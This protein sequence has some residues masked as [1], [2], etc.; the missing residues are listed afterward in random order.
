MV[1]EGA[2]NQ[3]GG[4]LLKAKDALTCLHNSVFPKRPP[5]ASLG[6]LAELLGLEASTIGDFR[7]EQMVCGSQSTLLMLPRHGFECDFDKT[8]SVVPRGPD[9]KALSLSSF[10]ARSRKLA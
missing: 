8:L 1:V 5:P 6:E 4:L 7:R 3:V 9:G 2:G 10:S